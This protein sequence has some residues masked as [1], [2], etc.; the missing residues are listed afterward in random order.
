MKNNSHYTLS[1]SDLL[2]GFLFIFI[3]ILMKFIKDYH[4]KKDDLSKPLT[5]RANLLYDLKVKIEKKDIRIEIDEENGIMELPEILCFEKSKYKLNKKQEQKLDEICGIFSKI[6]CYADFKKTKK[7]YAI[8]KTDWKD[9]IP[10]SCKKQTKIRKNLNCKD[11]TN[12]LIDTI[13]IEGHA[14]SSPI[15]EFIGQGIKTNMDLAMKRSQTVFRFLT[16][17]EEEKGGNLAKGNHF[18][19]L[20]NEREEPLFGVTSYGDL[21]SSNQTNNREPNSLKKDRCV[22]IRF[23]MSQPKDLKKEFKTGKIK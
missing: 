13:L 18:Y 17:Y 22:N 21:R 6:I 11:Q 16:Q 12:G 3:I 9:S 7:K 14:D 10:Q 1:I 19:Y 8:W 15:F 4:D 23:I 2:M 20:L 5:E